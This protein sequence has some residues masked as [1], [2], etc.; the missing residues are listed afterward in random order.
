[1][2]DG[3]ICRFFDRIHCSSRYCVLWQLDSDSEDLNRTLTLRLI[4]TGRRPYSLYSGERLSLPGDSTYAI[5]YR[6]S[7]L[8]LHHEALRTSVSDGPRTHIHSVHWQATHA[9]LLDKEVLLAIDTSESGGPPKTNGSLG[10]PTRHRLSDGQ[11]QAF[12]SFGNTTMSGP[13]ITRVAKHRIPNVLSVH[14]VRAQAGDAR[15]R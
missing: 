4:N 6:H 14:A 15:R 7:S 2:V 10:N 11:A 9:Q 8:L 1:M 5:Q 3:E 12:K 13:F